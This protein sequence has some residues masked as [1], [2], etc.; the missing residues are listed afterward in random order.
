MFLNP[1]LQSDREELKA[2]W[3]KVQEFLLFELQSDREELK[4][5]FAAA[6]AMVGYSF[7]RTVRN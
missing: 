3:R 5:I 7:N 4:V 6:T 2:L 1:W